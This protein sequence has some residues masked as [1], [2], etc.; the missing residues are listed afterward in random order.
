MQFNNS[1]NSIFH[2][3]HIKESKGQ[4]LFL[5]DGE[6]PTRTE[7]EAHI[8]TQ[9][10]DGFGSLDPNTFMSFAYQEHDVL[11]SLMLKGEDVYK[12]LNLQSFEYYLTRTSQPMK[13]HK[14]GT[15]AWFLLMNMN[16]PEPYYFGTNYTE[17]LGTMTTFIGTVGLFSSGCDMEMETTLLMDSVIKPGDF[18]LILGGDYA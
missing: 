17:A 9:E 7:I 13:M 11:A 4:T 1:M 6:C 2:G 14:A 3:T 12:K 5:F 10:G 18:E 15:V 16:T 8:R